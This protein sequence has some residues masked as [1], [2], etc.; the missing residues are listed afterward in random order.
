MITPRTGLSCGFLLATSLEKGQGRV[1]HEA[2]KNGTEEV[3]YDIDRRNGCKSV[4]GGRSVML[5]VRDWKIESVQPGSQLLCK[6]PE[7]LHAGEEFGYPV[8]V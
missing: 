5:S 8:P 7:S 3:A 1:K 6:P 2:R 4:V